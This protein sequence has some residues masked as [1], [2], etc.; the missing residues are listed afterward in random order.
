VLT[1]VLHR[2]AASKAKAAPALAA[3]SAL[4]T[5]GII[6]AAHPGSHPD[7]TAAT[8]S[9][10][11]LAEPTVDSTTAPTREVAFFAPTVTATPCPKRSPYPC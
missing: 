2:L 4:I 5:M 7:A 10:P 8:L 9:P 11:S 6:T 3:A 1:Q